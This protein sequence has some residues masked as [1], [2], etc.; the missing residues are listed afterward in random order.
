MPKAPKSKPAKPAPR[1]DPAAPNSEQLQTFLKKHGVNT[2]SFEKF[3]QV[4]G[5]P[6]YRLFADGPDAIKL[7]V[8]LRSLVDKTGYWPLVMGQNFGV[9]E[10]EDLATSDKI[11]AG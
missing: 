7:W 8:K 10:P 6:V 1:P 3:A 2:K 4:E 5:K 11:S 9:W